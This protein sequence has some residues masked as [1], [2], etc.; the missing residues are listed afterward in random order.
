MKKSNTFNTFLVAMGFILAAAAGSR[1]QALD[2]DQEIKKHEAVIE[3]V[4]QSLQ[5]SASE[6]PTGADE[7][8]QGLADL[9]DED[10]NR[11]GLKV[12]LISKK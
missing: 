7:E 4:T 2:F 5:A 10:S 3:Q 9:E 11:D 6:A 1:A 8:P 12:V